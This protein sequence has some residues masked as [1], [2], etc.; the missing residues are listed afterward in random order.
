V[1]LKYLLI[2]L[3]LIG[4]WLGPLPLWLTLNF[5]PVWLSVIEG[6]IGTAGMVLTLFGA[7]EPKP[8]SPTV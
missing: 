5:L 7:L 6:I 4:A 8:S 1:R 3:A 2:G